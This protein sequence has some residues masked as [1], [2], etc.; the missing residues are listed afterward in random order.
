MIRPDYIFSYWIFGW[1]VIY[2][3]GL[4]KHNPKFALYLGVLENF[5]VL[6]SMAYYKVKV[7]NILYFSVLI[8]LLK[9]LPL[10]T[11]RN[12]KIQEA[13]LYATA[14]VFLMFIGWIVWDEQLNVLVESYTQMLNNRNQLPGMILLEKIFH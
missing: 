14:G 12:T 1:Y 9:L 13:D 2:M 3:M 5:F 8:I 4:V 7:K 10:W 6:A 11:L